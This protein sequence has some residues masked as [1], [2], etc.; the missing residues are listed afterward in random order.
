MVRNYVSNDIDL[1]KS[2][3][4]LIS[5]NWGLKKPPLAPKM[6]FTFIPLPICNKNEYSELNLPDYI[7]NK[8]L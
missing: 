3:Q 5:K 7:N 1:I 4:Y 8:D 6:P 2:T